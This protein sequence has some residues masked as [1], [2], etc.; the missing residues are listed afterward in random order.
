MCSYSPDARN[1]SSASFTPYQAKEL[2]YEPLPNLV[3]YLR[4]N[5]L[6]MKYSSVKRTQPKFDIPVNKRAIAETQ[7]AAFYD[8]GLMPTG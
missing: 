3:D 2:S 5:G 1:A 4:K 8:T 6:T 7:A